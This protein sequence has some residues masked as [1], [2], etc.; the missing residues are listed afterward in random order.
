[1]R[2]MPGQVRAAYEAELE[3]GRHT[4]GA[5]DRQALERAHILSQPWAGPH[6]HAHWRMLQRACHERDVHEVSGQAMRL[7]IAGPGSMTNR[8]PPG[9]NGRARVSARLPM[10]I[11]NDLAALLDPA[12]RDEQ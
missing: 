12:I 5:E 6:V 1:M 8:Y 2:V 9:N 7:V 10:P 11:P 4:A 3:L